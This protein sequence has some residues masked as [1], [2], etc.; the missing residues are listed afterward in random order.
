M[1]HFGVVSDVFSLFV[2]VLV[3]EKFI[4][5]ILSQ[6]GLDLGMG[7]DLGIDIMQLPI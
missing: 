3:G 6:Q 7:L 5:F 2:Y 1:R 4:I